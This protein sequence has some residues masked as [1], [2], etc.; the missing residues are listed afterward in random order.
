MSVHSVVT[1]GD[2]SDLK[3]ENST[4]FGADMSFCYLAYSKGCAVSLPLFHFSH[5]NSVMCGEFTLILPHPVVL[6]CI[7]RLC[8]FDSS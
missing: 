2:C 4:V 6:S 5:L 1:C 8:F 3:K 7:N